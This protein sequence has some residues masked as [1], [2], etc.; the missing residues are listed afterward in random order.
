[1]TR[2]L[3]AEGKGDIMEKNWI[4]SGYDILSHFS[5][6]NGQKKLCKG[7]YNWIITGFIGR[8]VHF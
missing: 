6:Q 4:Q 8:F 7:V 5:L 2:H 1:M 3:K